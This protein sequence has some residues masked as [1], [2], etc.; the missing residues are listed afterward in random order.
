MTCSA[1]FSQDSEAWFLKTR[2]QKK[3]SLKRA[4]SLCSRSSFKN[5]WEISMFPQ[6]RKTL[7]VTVMSPDQFR[8]ANLTDSVPKMYDCISDTTEPNH[9]IFLRGKRSLSSWGTKTKM[10]QGD[11]I[12]ALFLRILQGYYLKIFCIL[13]KYPNQFPVPSKGLRKSREARHKRQ[14]RI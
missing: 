11:K 2:A 1:C 7:Q 3:G 8:K 5:H 10:Q 4:N 9:L 12:R 13:E 14:S 6:R